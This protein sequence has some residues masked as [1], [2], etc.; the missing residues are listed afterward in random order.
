MGNKAYTGVGIVG[1]IFLALGVM[2][3][4]QGDSWVVWVLLGVILGG[5]GTARQLLGGKNNR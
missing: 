3:F 5:V 2:R 4:F 1:L